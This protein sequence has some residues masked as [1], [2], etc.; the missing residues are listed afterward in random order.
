MKQ[1]AGYNRERGIRR[2][3]ARASDH[4]QR[5]ILGTRA[6]PGIPGAVTR[7]AW[8]GWNGDG[9]QS[10]AMDLDILFGVSFT[11]TYWAQGSSVPPRPPPPAH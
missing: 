2:Q 5:G 10:R 7:L 4:F 3:G 11:P 9:E 6:S 8:A 1:T